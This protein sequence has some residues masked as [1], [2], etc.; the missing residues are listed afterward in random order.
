[1]K[2]FLILLAVIGMSLTAQAQ[3][4]IEM[5]TEAS[6]KH[7]VATNSFWANWFVQANGTTRGGAFAIGKWF[8]PGL[9]LR[10]KMNIGLTSRREN[11]DYSGRDNQLTLDEQ[12][13]FNITNMVM[14]YHERRIWNV[15]PFVGAGLNRNTTLNQNVIQVTYGLQNAFRLSKKLSAQVEITRNI[16][17]G[18]ADL[19]GLK[20]HQK[21]WTFE[22]GLTYRLGN[23]TWKSAP[24]VESIR[25]LSQSEIDALNAQLQDAQMEIDQLR[26]EL[27]SKEMPNE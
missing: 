5:T 9:A 25:A 11:T 12:V 24:D 10:T 26:Q 21:Q 14:G 19:P 27:E 3:D 18:K 4:E 16:W 8:T 22:V 1:M 23:S 7:S 20:Q 6:E 2:K 13:L 17:N 15:I